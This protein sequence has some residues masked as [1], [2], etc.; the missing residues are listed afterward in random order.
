MFVGIE[1]IEHLRADRLGR[2]VE[3]HLPLTN[4]DHP[5]KV[6]Q[7]QLD[8]MQAG[9]QRYTVGLG[10]AVEQCQAVVG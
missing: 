6:R 5:W 4:A 10:V 2:A 3:H 9:H 8:R 1:C 7:R